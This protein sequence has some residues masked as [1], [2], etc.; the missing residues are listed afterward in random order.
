MNTCGLVFVFSFVSMRAC[1]CVKESTYL[2]S[3]CS[4]SKMEIHIFSP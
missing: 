4:F 1:M 3:C 2:N